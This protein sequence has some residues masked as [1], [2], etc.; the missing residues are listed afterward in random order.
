VRSRPR[1]RWTVIGALLVAVAALIAIISRG[2]GPGQTDGAQISHVALTSRLVHRSM[3]VTLVTPPGGGAHRPLL[4]FLHG[5][6]GDQNSELSEQFFSALRALGATAPDVVFP[7]GGD[8]SYWHNRSGSAWGSYV[9]REVI[10]A[11][12]KLTDADPRRIAIGGISMG[13]FGAYD[14]ARLQ[15]RRF[16]AIGGHS[17]ALWTSAGDAAAGAFDDRADF[18]RHDVIAATRARPGLYGNARLWLDGGDEDPFHSADETLAAVLHIHMHVWPGAHN[19][20]YWNAH[21]ADYL[22]FYAAALAGCRLPG[23]S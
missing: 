2:T 15:P 20:D 12:L 14:L 13:G 7:D 10:P 5:R 8:H 4:V 21:M 1:R 17:A 22:D 3:P 6:G 16:C 19:S 23:A 11:A 18:A 9:L